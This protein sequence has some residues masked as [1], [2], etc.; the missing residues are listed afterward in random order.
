MIVALALTAA[1]VP[2]PALAYPPGPSD[3]PTPAYC[4]SILGYDDVELQGTSLEATRYGY[5]CARDVHL[6]LYTTSTVEYYDMAL[7][8]AALFLAPELAEFTF[9]G[10]AG[11]ISNAL[12]ALQLRGDTS[13]LAALL[14]TMP[15]LTDEP[16]YTTESWAPYGIARTNAEAAIADGSDV[17]SIDVMGLQ[18]ALNV[19]FPGL[20]LVDEPP[21]PPTPGAALLL[22]GFLDAIADLAPAEADYTSATWAPFAA[23]LGAAQAIYAEGTPTDAAATP[24]L[25]DLRAA[26]TGLVLASTAA[27]NIAALNAAIAAAQAVIS[28]TGVYTAASVATVTAAITAAQGATSST[29]QATIDALYGDIIAALAALDVQVQST[30]NISELAGFTQALAALNLTAATYT[31]ASW[32]N[33][34]TALANANAIVQAGAGATTQ[35]LVDAALA[36]LTSAV[37]GLVVATPTPGVTTGALAGMIAGLAALNL[38]ASDYTTASWTAYAQALSAANAIIATPPATQAPVDT[39]A[40]ALRLAAVGLTP[41]PPAPP[42]PDASTLTALIAIVESLDL[43]ASDYTA[44][45]WSA[46]QTALG[47]AKAIGSGAT[48]TQID[49]AATALRNAVDALTPAVRTAA[50]ASAIATAEALSATAY[51]TASWTV[52]QN[53][54]TSARSVLATPTNQT[55]VDA[56]VTALG[57]AIGALVPVEQ[58]APTVHREGLNAAIATAEALAPHAAAWTTASW[59]AVTTALNAARSVPTSATQSAV[60]TATN[61]L[62]TAIGN[63]TAAPVITPVNFGELRGYLLAI[64]AAAPQQAD[65]TTATWTPFAQARTAAQQVAQNSAATQT[66]IDAALA[67]LRTAYGNLAL[68]PVTQPI[69]TAALTAAIAAGEAVMASP[70]LYSAGSLAAVVT[71]L[72]AARNLDPTSQA[73]VDS[74]VSTL[75]TAIQG[76]TIRVDLDRLAGFTEALDAL[77]LDQA[78]YTVATWSAYAAAK[79]AASAIILAG[80]DATTQIAADSALTTLAAAFAALAPIPQVPQVSTGHLAGILAGVEALSAASYTQASWAALTATVDAARAVL[81]NPANQAAVDEAEAAVR[82]AIVALAPRVNTGA[83][84]GI[85][86]GIGALDEAAYT[87]ESWAAFVAVLDAAQAVLAAPASQAAANEAEAAVRAAITA[88]APRVTTGPLSGILTGVDA[89]DAKAYTPASWTALT[90][91]LTAARAILENPSSQAAADNAAAAVRAAILALVPAEPAKAPDDSDGPDKPSTPSEPDPAPRLVELNTV[92]ADVGKLQSATYTAAS[93]AVLLAALEEARALAAA[94]P[95]ATAAQ[96]SAAN[97]KIASAMAG[98]QLVPSG[99]GVTDLGGEQIAPTMVAVKAQQSKVTL[100]R[101]RSVTL[102]ALGHMSNGTTVK[103]AWKSANSKIATVSAKGKITAKKAGKTTITVTAG[104]K[105]AKVAVRVLKSRPAKTAVAKVS[106]KGVAKTMRVGA[107]RNVTGSWTPAT[108]PSVTVTYTSSK[109]SVASI[110]ETGRLVAKTKGN[111]VITVKAGAKSKNY[112][113]MVV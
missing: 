84:A 101:G 86:A 10:A 26:A 112:K 17:S 105:T 73:V 12:V 81:A 45:T 9:H 59:G 74:A 56:A 83:L 19:A 30:V 91:A 21:P 104:G 44:T 49:S 46:Y 16:L 32:A 79:S 71:A 36:M 11:F 24:K 80:P 108:A 53:A 62:V 33:Y 72:N 90:V 70:G 94:N 28:Q 51:T 31:P 109:A 85:L 57:T 37:G 113:V 6:A 82:A 107:A 2:S 15:P 43:V 67:T 42:T 1:S 61:T 35:P 39:A 27:S 40:E 38:Q 47:A 98:L 34:A 58:P 103:V 25:A 76:L 88:L 22:R 75:L 13:G 93:W 87:P 55:A 20:V 95:P 106:A 5:D 54:L 68:V 14:A 110:D 99:P 92:L 3:P 48:Q 18:L 69:N 60:D 89:L 23:A 52:F 64:E 41:A 97:A 66:A 96:L 65:Y 111:A 77:D 63:L 4:L 100:V 102:T 29:P 50:L 8:T 78:D 7:D